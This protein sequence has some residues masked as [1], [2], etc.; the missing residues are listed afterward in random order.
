MFLV[1]PIAWISEPLAHALAQSFPDL[2]R[3][4][5]MNQFLDPPRDSES[6]FFVDHE[7]RPGHKQ[8]VVMLAPSFREFWSGLKA[9]L[10]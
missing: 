7:Y 9:A 6:V 8:R 4:N 2:V 5:R 1:R 10:P 3:L